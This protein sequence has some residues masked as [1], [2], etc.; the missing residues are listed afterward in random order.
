MIIDCDLDFDPDSHDCTHCKYYGHCIA[1]AYPKL[2]DA[3][4]FLIFE[5]SD[6]ALDE[7]AECISN[8]NV[9][10]IKYR[11]DNLKAAIAKAK[12]QEP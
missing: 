10:C 5:L 4:R 8:T 1:E 6:W 2:W 12:G 9:E 3:C 7:S 11:R